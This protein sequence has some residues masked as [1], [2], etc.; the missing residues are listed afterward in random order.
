MEAPPP[1]VLTVNKRYFIEDKFLVVD[2]LYDQK[3][4]GPVGLHAGERVIILHR[5]LC[6]HDISVVLEDKTFT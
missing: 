3:V 6:N 2:C 4:S 5:V 1:L